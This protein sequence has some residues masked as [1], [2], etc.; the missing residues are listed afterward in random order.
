MRDGNHACQNPIFIML[1][2]TREPTTLPTSEARG[3]KAIFLDRDGTLNK[4]TG[5]LIG[6]EDFELLPGVET[7]LHI[8]QDLGYR[9]FVVSNQSGVARGYFTF[10]AVE[11]LHRRIADHLAGKGVRIDEMVFCPHHPLGK[12]ARYT[13]DCDCRK[14]KPGM[15]L[16]LQATHGLDLSRSYMIGDKLSDAE[17]GVNAG[18][19]GIWLTGSTADDGADAGTRRLDNAGNIKEFDSLLDFARHLGTSEGLRPQAPAA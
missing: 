13:M 11:A 14:P 19:R 7:A 18:A 10:E 5:Y 15:L 12:D 3:R 2:T 17:T 4:D 8:F 9:L 16:R 1:R 6:F